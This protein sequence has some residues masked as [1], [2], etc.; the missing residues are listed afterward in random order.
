MRALGFFP[1]DY[2]IECLQHELTLR[3]RRKVPF[4]ELVKLFI[5]HSRPSSSRALMEKSLRRAMKVDNISEDI[6]T[7][8][9]AI[10]VRKSNLLPMLTE[11][12]E[13]IDTK[14]A[15]LH[16]KEIFVDELGKA[17]DELA[18]SDFLIAISSH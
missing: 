12:A 5:N 2:E 17:V 10:I 3:G 9:A 8:D 18:M 11:S 16:L 13:K 6:S 7:T 4:E 15:D 1:S 14:D